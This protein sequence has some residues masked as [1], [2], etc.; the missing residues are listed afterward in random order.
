M[1]AFPKVA[2]KDLEGLSKLSGIIFGLPVNKSCQ[3]SDWGIR[4]LTSEQMH[5][6][7]LDAYILT[8]LFD[9]LLSSSSLAAADS[10]TVLDPLVADYQI[11]FPLLATH[12]TNSNHRNVLKND[13]VDAKPVTRLTVKSLVLLKLPSYSVFKL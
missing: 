3:C 4:P 13:T 12:G 2:K 5:Y 1:K 9:A 6:A 11:K 8:R 10:S 7:A